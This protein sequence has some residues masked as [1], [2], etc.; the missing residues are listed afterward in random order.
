MITVSV[1][2]SNYDATTGKTYALCSFV[3]DDVADLPSFDSTED[4]VIQMGSKAHVIANNKDYRMKS[5]GTWVENPEGGSGGGGGVVDAYT[6]A[7][8]DELLDERIPYSVNGTITSGEDLD[9]YYS[10]G[11]WIAPSTVINSPATAEF[12]LDVIQVG[13]GRTRQIIQ[14]TGSDV[15]TFERNMTSDP[16]QFSVAQIPAMTSDTAP[17]GQVIYSGQY[18]NRYGYQAFDGVDSQT[19]QRNSWGDGTNALDGTP[20]KCYVGYEFAAPV[21]INGYSISFSSDRT[22]VGIIQTRTNNVWT[23]RATVSIAN[24]GYSSKTG[25]FEETVECDAVRFCV[26]SG[27]GSYFTT[28]TYGGNVCEFQVYLNDFKPTWSDWYQISKTIVQ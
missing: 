15:K 22:Y 14:Q 16:T 5:D 24:N 20:E 19:W 11:S 13:E 12:R 26:L 17:S 2:S 1:E 10:V 8:T 4:Y 9:L 21:R 23:T 7:E 18:S 28:S 27:A 3:C 6:K 25:D